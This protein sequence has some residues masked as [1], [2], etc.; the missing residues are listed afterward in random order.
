M[1]TF[2]NRLRLDFPQLTFSPG[3]SYYWCPATREIFYKNIAEVRRSD[4]WA[5]LHEVSH[6]LLEHTAYKTD[7]EL[8]NLEVAAWDKAQVLAHDYRLSISGDYIQ[9][10]LDTYR[11]WLYRRCVCPRCGTQNLQQDDGSCYQC[12]NCHTEWRV[13]ASRFTRAYRRK[14]SEARTDTGPEPLVIFK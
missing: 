11:D 10:C 1:E 7:W 14:S 13:S 8:L 4:K 3:Q 12:Y 9:D 2:V 5:L 6:A